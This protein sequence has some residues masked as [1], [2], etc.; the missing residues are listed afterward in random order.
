MRKRRRTKK[1]WGLRNE[2]D[3]DEED[4]SPGVSRWR[5]EISFYCSVSLKTV[6]DLMKEFRGCLDSGITDIKLRIHSCGGDAYA[7]L[8]AHDFLIGVQRGSHAVRL[9][10]VAEGC[11]A[12]AA[13]FLLIAG[14]RR[15]VNVN[16]M[17]L[18]H[19]L[20]VGNYGYQ[21]FSE[22]VEDLNANAK[23]MEMLKKLYTS[24][25]GIPAKKL[26]ELLS[27]EIWMNADECRKFSVATT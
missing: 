4:D 17:V 11:C 1:A 7:G 8:A 10:T 19:Q 25:T 16:A 21:K 9:T 14:E 3:E 23:M 2:S 22:Q 20:R 24:K 15:E 13:T 12:S 6:S 5:N 27:N 26:D 18:I